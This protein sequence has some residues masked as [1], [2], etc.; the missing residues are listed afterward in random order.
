MNNKLGLV[1]VSFRELTPFQIIDLMK[2]VGISVVEW[3][4]DV[5]A[6][7]KGDLQ[8][9]EIA[10]YQKKNGIYKTFFDR[11]KTFLCIRLALFSKIE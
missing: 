11:N 8:L 7:C 1:S 2:S 4:S 3:G 9:M 10:E 5:H 6:P